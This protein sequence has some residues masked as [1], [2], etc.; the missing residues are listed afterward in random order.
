[1]FK[2]TKEQQEKYKNQYL[3]WLQ[4]ENITI[5]DYKEFIAD[6]T[7]IRDVICDFIDDFYVTDLEKIQENLVEYVYDK[8]RH[9]VGV[10]HAQIKD[11]I[12][13]FG[14]WNIEFGTVTISLTVEN[15]I[16]KMSNFFNGYPNNSDD[17]YEDIEI[18]ILEEIVNNY[19]K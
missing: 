12:L 15:N 6:Y 11:E 1:M 3:Q 9:V 2:L 5:N 10:T 16:L 18:N 7:S 14:Y 4:E 17:I 19:N 13:E 8:L